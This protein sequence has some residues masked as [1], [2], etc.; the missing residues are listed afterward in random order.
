MRLY[1]I[2]AARRAAGLQRSGRVLAAA[3]ALAVAWGSMQPRPAEAHAPIAFAVVKVFGVVAGGAKLTDYQAHKAYQ[4]AP[5]P[6]TCADRRRLILGML[7]EA[8]RLGHY[9]SDIY[10]HGADAKAGGAASQ[11]LGDGRTAFYEPGGRHYAEARVDRERG[12]VVVVFRGTRLSVGGDISTNVLSGLGVN[13]SY[14][15]WAAALVG[16]VKREHPDL[17]VVVTGHSLGGG[18]AIY[19][20]LQNPGVRGVVFNPAGLSWVT[21]LTTRRAERARTSEAVTVVSMRNAEHIEPITAMSLA[22]RT[23]LPGHLFILDAGVSG[24]LKLH[25]TTT[26][27]ATLERLQRTAA[28]GDACDSVLGMLA[29]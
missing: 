10:D 21:W 27:E 1:G 23:V 7:P 15:R 12:E 2:L 4:K 20:V 14:Y 19:A 5:R 9:A 18:L 29:H 8:V 28:E 24:P 17:L 26:I 6:G 3:V 11:A 22:H 25:S 13:T 16:R